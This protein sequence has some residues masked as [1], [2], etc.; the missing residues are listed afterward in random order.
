MLDRQRTVLR[1]PFDAR[2][3]EKNVD[4]GQVV[5]TQSVLAT[6]I[7]SDE[8]WIEATLPVEQLRWIDVPSSGDTKSVNAGS[9]VVVRQRLT[10]ELGTVRRGQVLGL[11][12]G[13]QDK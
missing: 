6:L 2:V 11:L 10:G 7:A 8:V 5:S 9:S 13:L 4:V 12:P 1:A 3:N